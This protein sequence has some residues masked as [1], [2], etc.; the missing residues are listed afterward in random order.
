MGNRL[1]VGNLP[2]SIGAEA[3]REAF[4]AH[5]DVAD[6]HIVS[7]RSTGQPRGFGFVTMG[8]G[9]EAQK[10]IEAMNG[11]MLE[12]RA[13]RVN[14]AEERPERSGGGGGGGGGRGGGGGGGRGGGG[15]GGGG[16]RGRW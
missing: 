11:A 13:L 16:G 6:V 14:E 7:D 3:L 15:G 2:F 5:G 4:S 1:Y 8:N 12:G 10:A 9:H